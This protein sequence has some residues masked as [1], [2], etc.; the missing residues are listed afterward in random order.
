MS[1]KIHIDLRNVQETLLLPLWGRAVESQKDFPLLN[2]KKSLEII[3]SIDYDFTSI[4]K[5][6]RGL[7][8]LAW[9]G[10]ALLSDKIVR[11]FIEKY[12]QATIVDIGCGMDTNFERVDNGSIRW[13]DIDLSPVIELRKKF[14]EETGRRKFI[15]SSLFDY[16][17]MDK[18]EIK[19]K[20]LFI[21]AGVLYYFS[22]MEVKEFLI[23]MAE[24]FHGSEFLFDVASPAGV[25]T[26]NEVVLKNVSMSETS[27]LRWGLKKT[28]D[29]ESWDRDIK[30][31]RKYSFYEDLRK[32]LSFRNKLGTYMSDFLKIMYMIHIEIR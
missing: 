9:I 28:R 18:I 16:T 7:S 30:I 6:T 27:I 23:K 31:I 11:E 14:M 10:R 15:I 20:V 29:I 1:A 5:N 32:G 2:D 24:V 8:Q 19:E 17:W 12:P 25:R 26:A 3:N 13:Y 21:S 4:S 22:E